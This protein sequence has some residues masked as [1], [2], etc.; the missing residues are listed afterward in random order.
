[1][2]PT[3]EVLKF[4]LHLHICWPSQIIQ[5]EFSCKISGVSIG[6]IPPQEI[7]LFASFGTKSKFPIRQRV[8]DRIQK[9]NLGDTLDAYGIHC[10]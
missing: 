1:M 3:M 9:S 2:L 6:E 7:S 8:R 4:F 5:A 10:C